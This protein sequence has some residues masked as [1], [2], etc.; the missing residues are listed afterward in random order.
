M[1]RI[2]KLANPLSTCNEFKEISI[3]PA[4]KIGLAKD[5]AFTFTYSHLIDSWRALG[6]EIMT[7][8]PLNDEPPP[9]HADFIWLPGGYP[10]LH[11]CFC[12]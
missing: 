9:K 7:F 8:S 1:A 10:E 2:E 6:A 4:Q 11:L 12:W 5:H 3:P